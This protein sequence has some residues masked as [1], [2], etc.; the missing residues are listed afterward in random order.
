MRPVTPRILLLGDSPGDAD[1]VVAA[2]ARAGHAASR[3]RVATRREMRR[4]DERRELLLAKV[5][6]ALE[7]SGLAARFLEIE[8]TETAVMADAAQAGATLRELNK[9]GVRI[10]LDDL[11]TG[12]S[13]LSLFSSLPIHTVKIIRSFVGGML[14]HDRDMT[15][16]TSVI[17]LGHR[18]GRNVVADGVETREQLAVLREHGCD[19]M[20]G[21]LF[22][23]PHSAPECGPLLRRHRLLD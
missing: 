22:A 18:L 14:R 3:V 4:T 10:A 17:A 21:Y 1:A 6:R 5:S 8:I 13:S 9:L 12:Y 19:E 16:V 11:G 2:F 7:V 23:R 20:Q 15:I